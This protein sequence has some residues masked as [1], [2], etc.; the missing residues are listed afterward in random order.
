MIKWLRN[1]IV[2]LIG[3]SLIPVVKIFEEIDAECPI[4]C[5]KPADYT[6]NLCTLG[7]ELFFYR[8]SVCGQEFTRRNTHK[9]KRF[10]LIQLWKL[11]YYPVSGEGEKYK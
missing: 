4:H 10:S 11:I 6:G 2:F 5:D 3:L 8:C 9:G 1:F 7:G